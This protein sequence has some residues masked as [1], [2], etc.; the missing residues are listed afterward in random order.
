MDPCWP[1]GISCGKEDRSALCSAPHWPFSCSCRACLEIGMM[2]VKCQ[3]GLSLV[4]ST[5]SKDKR[6]SLPCAIMRHLTP[7]YGGLNWET[8][9]CSGGG[10]G[11][12]WGSCWGRGGWL[13]CYPSFSEP[14]ISRDARW[15]GRFQQ[16]TGRMTVSLASLLGRHKGFTVVWLCAVWQ[17]PCVASVVRCS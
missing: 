6:L 7:E 8:C 1:A 5:G 3:R 16:E 14:S 12:G 13:L 4:V 17:L 10:G 11:G 2:S 9:A 15:D